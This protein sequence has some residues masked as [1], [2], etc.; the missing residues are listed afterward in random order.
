MIEIRH[1][2]SGATASFGWTEQEVYLWSC[3]MCL[4]SY[5]LRIVGA[6]VPFLAHFGTHHHHQE[7]GA[8][9]AF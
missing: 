7:L 4:N 9:S 1:A 5:I 8:N 2:H 6:F 3:G